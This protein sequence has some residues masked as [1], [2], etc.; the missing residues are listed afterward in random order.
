MNEAVAVSRNVSACQLPGA[1]FGWVIT[2]GSGIKGSEILS[3]GFSL[4][5]HR[6]FPDSLEEIESRLGADFI[7][8]DESSPET[9]PLEGLPPRTIRITRKTSVG[10]KTGA[11]APKGDSAGVATA[12]ELRCLEYARSTVFRPDA[13]IRGFLLKADIGPISFGHVYGDDSRESGEFCR[14]TAIGVDSRVGYEI[15]RVAE[16]GAYCIVSYAD[17]AKDRGLR[18]LREHIAANPDHYA[19]LAAKWSESATES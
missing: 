12:D 17:Y 1:F 3:Y 6:L 10:L 9:V 8:A 11:A 4:A 2:F 19:A 18:F 14:F 16:G 7:V 5:D 13:N 15:V